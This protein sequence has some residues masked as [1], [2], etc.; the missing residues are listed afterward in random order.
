MSPTTTSRQEAKSVF[1]IEIL[2]GPANL[3]YSESETAE[4][5]ARFLIFPVCWKGKSV[6][7]ELG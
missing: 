5:F 4:I 1:T 7:L 3:P 2:Q 6:G